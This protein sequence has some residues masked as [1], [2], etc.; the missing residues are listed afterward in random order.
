MNNNTN[1]NNNNNNNELDLFELLKY[2]LDCEYISD[3]KI[4]P[5]NTKAKLILSFINL[6]KFSLNQ[7]KDIFEYIHIP[8]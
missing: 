3:L 6:K 1:N 8:L 5:Y 4:E 2:I 7:I